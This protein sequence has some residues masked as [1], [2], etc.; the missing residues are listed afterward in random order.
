[1]VGN[2]KPLWKKLFHMESPI[3]WGQWIFDRITNNWPWLLP[4]I[5]ASIMYRLAQLS[6]ALKP[7]G[8]VAWAT[9]ALLA[10]LVIVIARWLIIWGTRVRI[11]N[12]YDE[13]MLSG[14][15]DFN[16]LDKTFVSKRIFV[17]DFALPS[18][19]HIEGKVF[20]DC[21]I[22][23][24]ANLY[25]FQ[26]N[27]AQPI[28]APVV[29]VVILEPGKLFNSGFIMRDCIFTN[30]SFQRITVFAGAHYYEVWKDNPNVNFISCPP[31][32]PELPHINIE[33]ADGEI[34]A[35]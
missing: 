22:I 26:N 2:E 16:P 4:L 17:N 7:Y 31:R 6:E 27:N 13:R 8:Y 11:N 21:D 3:S 30:C 34:H 25:W 14:G 35:A 12:R 1:M 5:G 18:H 19:P 29:D 10:A 9:I 24:P 20:I 15:A 23:G 32:Q 28:R 33:T